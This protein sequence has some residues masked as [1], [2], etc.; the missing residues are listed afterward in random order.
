M[1]KD[2]DSEMFLE[3]RIKLYLKLHIFAYLVIEPTNS[4]DQLKLGFL[5]VFIS[6]SYKWCNFYFYN[7]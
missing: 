2:T 6:D 4:L 1:T 7:V 3:A 5:F